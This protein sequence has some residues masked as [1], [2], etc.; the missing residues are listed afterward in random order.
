MILVE[1]NNDEHFIY[2]LCSRLNFSPVF[3]VK[4]CES[5]ELLYKKLQAELDS[6][7][8]QPLGI[9][10]DSDENIESR[11]SEIQKLVK[12]YYSLTSSD[13]TPY[14]LVFNPG[15]EPKFG[16][17]IWPDNQ[18]NGILEDLYLDLVQDH[19]ALLEES[20]RVVE[21]LKTIEPWRFK[22]QH[23]S[24]AIVHTWLAWQDNPG[25][26]I[27]S[28]VQRTTIVINKPVIDNFKT[29]LTS[30]YA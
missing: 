18:K 13:F 4:N 15:N 30:L 2:N 8:T 20:K 6:D 25:S 28:S 22:K 3:K 14:G 10:V 7:R 26:P 24:K 12:P 9:I 16:V 19:D 29:W 1:G 23:K 21:N 11:K 17:W 27:G 5:I